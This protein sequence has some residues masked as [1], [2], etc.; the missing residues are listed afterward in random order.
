M[1]SRSHT[2]RRGD[3]AFS[4][5]ALTSLVSGLASIA[6][7]EVG[8]ANIGRFRFTTGTS[9]VGDATPLYATD[10]KVGPENIW[11]TGTRGRHRMNIFF[12][13]PTEI[14]QVHV[15]SGGDRDGAV[16]D[17]SFVYLD[18]SGNFISVPGAAFSGNTEAYLDVVFPTPVTTTQLQIVID[19]LQATVREVAVFPPLATPKQIGDGVNL[20]L[21]RQHRRAITTAS[22]TAGGS[23]RRAVVDGFVNDDEYWDG[24]STGTRWIAL[25]LQD[26]PETVPPTV[27]W[28]TTPIEIGSVHLYS[29]LASGARAPIERGRF[30]MLDSGSGVWMDIAGG[31]FSNNTQAS[32]SVDFDA[33]VTTAGLRLVVQGG[34]GVIREIVP[35]PPRDGGWPLGV[36]V[37]EGP[38]TDAMTYGDRFFGLRLVG[39]GLSL[40]SDGGGDVSL[41]GTHALMTQ[42]YQVL[43]NAGT[44]TYRIRSRVTGLCLEPENG[45]LADGAAVGETDYAGLP[46]QRW[47]LVPGG[48]GMTLVNSSSGLTLTAEQGAESW[49]L[50]Q[51]MPGAGPQEW[52]T[53]ELEHAPKK[54]TGGFPQLSG[55]F[56]NDWAYN[57]GPNDTFPSEV[58]FWPMQWGSFNWGQR[59]SLNP[60]WQRNGEPIVLMGYNEP[61]KVD[62]SN[63]PVSTS[64]GMWPRL[65]VQGLPL[66][67]PAVAGHPA[68]SPYIQDFMAQAEA[69]ELRLD[70][71][72]MH[73]YGGPNANSFINKITDAHNAWGRD[74]V[75]SEFSVVDWGDTNSWTND[76][77]Y[78]WFAEVLWRMEKL[79]YLHRYAV[80]IFT[81]DPSNPISDNRG[82]MLNAD[83]SL[84]P[85]GRLYAAWDGDTQ[86]RTDTPYLL[87]NKA[88][89]KRIGAVPG[90]TGEDSTL[91]G[92][93]GDDAAAFRWRLIPGSTAGNY[94]IESVSD[95]TVLSYTSRGLELAEPGSETGVAEFRVEEIQHG[96]FA[97]VET[98]LNRRLSSNPSQGGQIG[99]A[100]AGS[101][102]DDV[103]WRLA[104]VFGGVPGPVRGGQA[105]SLGGGDVLLGWE[106]HG[107]RDLLGFTISRRDGAGGDPEV[108]AAGLAGESFVDRVP[109]PGVYS[110]TI[111]AVG[112]TGESEIASLGVV[113]VDACPADFNADFVVDD[114]DV[115][116]AINAIG[117]GLDYD[118][119]G[120]ADF[121]DVIAFLRVYD[122]ACPGE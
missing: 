66:L 98:A 2:I 9:T 14:G 78:N 110:Y 47:R 95:A 20:H 18:G 80:F 113:S 119:D 53:E 83:G 37:V 22:G 17:L 120:S 112:D 84:T 88:S 30:Q 60:E 116:A 25:D 54:G 109:E 48:S 13:R 55:T 41:R 49:V 28:S 26:P 38:A 76:P 61:D 69:A 42:H 33:P 36:S 15:Y 3:A 10:G 89:Y 122:E 23:S 46:T 29:G 11:V 86:V 108:V 6:A 99:L 43:L 94:Q 87:H 1:F 65:E 24:G 102:S 67:G 96:W 107:F 4:V 103:R 100:S 40:Q 68:T 44:E 31:A 64:I 5:L 56:G 27:R 75:V 121:F 72:G 63:Q 45:S 70:Y 50:T 97:I 51:A 79:P 77:V 92:G 81:D 39:S 7:A 58:D 106:P 91:L 93:R 12:D 105:V 8:D 115:S 57:W 59:P 34:D 85:A 21:G 101:T 104:P 16:E 90:A 82:E 74:V 117:A 52:T 118:G 35:L 62:Q 32:L 73:S 114:A 19:D 71:V 111:T